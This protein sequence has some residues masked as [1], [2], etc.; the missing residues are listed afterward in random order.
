MTLKLCVSILAFALCLACGGGEQAAAP[1]EPKAA[2]AKAMPEDE[3]HRFSKEDRVSTE[4]VDD[5]LLGKDYLPGGNQAE[6]DRG[7]KKHQLYL[8]KTGS[9]EDAALLMF[10]IKG[11]LADAK[12]VPHFGGYFGMDGDE[13]TFVFPKNSYVAG[14][15]G[16]SQDD[17]DELAR[18][19]AGRLN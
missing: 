1:Q 6:Y 17:A 11:R 12:Y 8:I 16:L 7:G 18:H 3:S 5:N 9:P 10:D 14:I 4:V 13:P 19:F 2:P 15:V